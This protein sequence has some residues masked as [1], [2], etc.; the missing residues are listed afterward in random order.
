MKKITIGRTR[1]KS[2]AEIPPA[3]GNAQPFYSRSRTA[4]AVMVFGAAAV[5]GMLAFPLRS[6]PIPEKGTFPADET[7][8]MVMSF[9]VQTAAPVKEEVIAPSNADEEEW[10]FYDYIGELF[11]GLIS[12]Q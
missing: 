12:G 9:A 5:C 7:A 1:K 10:N 11:A 8:V 4:D 2:T 3:N 6:L